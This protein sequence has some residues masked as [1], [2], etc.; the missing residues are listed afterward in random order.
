[1]SNNIFD[2]VNE[3]YAQLG[4]DVSN[5]RE[6]KRNSIEKKIMEILLLHGDEGISHMY[7]AKA[8]GMDRKNLRKYMKSLIEQ[9]LIVRENGKH[10]K[11][12]PSTR[13]HQRK[14]LTADLIV[15]SYMRNILIDFNFLIESPYFK[16]HEESF[17]QVLKKDNSVNTAL[18][19][20]SNKIG[21]L[22]TYAI[23]ESLNPENIIGQDMTNK[24]IINYNLERWLDD[25][26]S[27]LVSYL[28]PIFKEYIY[29]Y[30]DCLI[31]K[32]SKNT[33]AELPYGDFLVY[34]DY[35]I[36]SSYLLD[37]EC[38]D[39]LH[40]AFFDIYPNLEDP[41]QK[42]KTNIPIILQKMKEDR[43]KLLEKKEKQ[44][45]CTHKFNKWYN[46]STDKTTFKCVKCDKL[47]YPY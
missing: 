36:N 43:K 11:Y 2:I 5:P 37:K 22:V 8:M 34:Q 35:L 44:L 47:K 18:F 23:I 41:L 10:G 17:R 28:Q 46:P 30:L 7:L 1:M 39:E 29:E 25:A 15:K 26:I 32:A 40:S 27:T 24:K 42:I 6:D 12:Y 19:N 21:A 38:I 14:D 13:L 16:Y 20:F 3:K 9:K 31:K 4:S 45:S 33:S